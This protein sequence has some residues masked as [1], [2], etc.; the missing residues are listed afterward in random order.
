MFAVII[1]AYFFGYRL[2]LKI[3]KEP[4]LSGETES[5]LV[6]TVKKERIEKSLEYFYERSQ[7]SDQ[8]LNSSAP[9]VDPSL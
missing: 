7:K 9:V 3:N 1:V 8:I 5:G 2:F 4:L 6:Q